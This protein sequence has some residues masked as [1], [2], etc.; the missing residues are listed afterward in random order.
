MTIECV[1]GCLLNALDNQEVN[2]I[3]HV[4]NCRG[5]M[6]GGIA[7]SIRERYPSVYEEYKA[8][9]EDTKGGEYLLGRAQECYISASPIDSRAVFNLHAQLDYGTHKRQLN[10]GALG[11][12]LF[13]ME[14]DSKG[15]TVG[16][17]YLLGC[18]LAGGDWSIVLEMI[19][20]YFKDHSVKI[21]KL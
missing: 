12:C 20:F 16:F 14:Q 2:V 4:V 8:F 11:K 9:H 7:K 17:P 13:Q 1:S 18:G 5:V 3:G 19:E 21:Y 10:Y 15:A 6:G